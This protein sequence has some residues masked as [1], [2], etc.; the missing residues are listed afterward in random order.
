MRIEDRIEPGHGRQ[1]RRRFGG[2]E[3]GIGHAARYRAARGFAPA[4]RSQDRP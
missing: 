2:G 4:S 1:L 3:A